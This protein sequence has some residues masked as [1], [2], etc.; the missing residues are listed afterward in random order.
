MTRLGVFVVV[1][2]AVSA[3]A[4]VEV[5]G[6]TGVPTTNVPTTTVPAAPSTALSTT[7]SGLPPV[8]QDSPCLQRYDPPRAAPP[9][10]YVPHLICEDDDTRVAPLAR[11]FRNPRPAIDAVLEGPTPDEAEVGFVAVGRVGGYDFSEG[12]DVIEVILDG[13][14]TPELVAAVKATIESGTLKTVTVR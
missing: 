1:V 6:S 8:W 10:G 7:S 9:D 14:A 4:P 2:L 11:G 5:T 3:C 12:E 13:P